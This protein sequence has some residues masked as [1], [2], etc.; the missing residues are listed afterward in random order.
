MGAYHDQDE[1]LSGTTSQAQL[2]RENNPYGRDFTNPK[3]KRRARR[4]LL[5][6]NKQTGRLYN[7]RYIRIDREKEN[8]ITAYVGVYNRESYFKYVL[9]RDGTSKMKARGLRKELKR[10]GRARKL[11]AREYFKGLQDI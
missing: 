10:R 4:K 8:L 5:P 1:L 3:G 7:A 9:A 11:G 2:N 6:I